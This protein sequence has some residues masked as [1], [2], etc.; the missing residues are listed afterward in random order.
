MAVEFAGSGIL[1]LVPGTVRASVGVYAPEGM[2]GTLLFCA[3]L[4]VAVLTFSDLLGFL[5]LGFLFGAFFL[6][7]F[8]LGFSFVLLLE[9]FL[10]SVC[11]TH[12]GGRAAG[13]VC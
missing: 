13:L 2:L 7:F 4:G 8:F 9:G 5:F 10:I 1:S 3:E 12:C 11:F 6:G